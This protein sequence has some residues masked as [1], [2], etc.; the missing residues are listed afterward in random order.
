MGTHLFWLKSLGNLRGSLLLMYLATVLGNLL[1]LTQPALDQ[2]VCPP[3]Y[4]FLKNL[5]LGSPSSPLPSVKPSTMLCLRASP[6][7]CQVVP[8]RYLPWVCRSHGALPPRC[9]VRWLLCCHLPPL[10]YEV[11]MSPRSCVGMMAACWLPSLFFCLRIALAIW[12][13]LGKA[14]QK[15]QPQ[16]WPQIIGAGPPIFGMWVLLLSP[17]PE[18]APRIQP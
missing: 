13:L 1:L 16:V 12:S 10:H 9:H 11:V 7:C 18:A 5:S 17:L 3:R 8:H 6:C 15:T 2:P 4:F 14:I